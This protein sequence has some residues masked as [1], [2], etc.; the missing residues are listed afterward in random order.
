MTIILDNGHGNNT[1][2]KCSPD[3]I[4]FEWKWTRHFA[5]LLAE[6]LTSR[7]I[8]VCMLVPED[9]DIGL[10]VRAIRANQLCHGQNKRD[11]LLIS[12]HNDA[13]PGTHGEWHDARGLTAFAHIHASEAACAFAKLIQ[14]EARANGF[15]GN[16]ASCAEGFKRANFAI[17]RETIMP[18]VLVENLFQDNKEDVRMLYTE[19]IVVKLVDIYERCICQYI[20]RKMYLL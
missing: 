9:R 18:A 4:H 11:F 6:R 1:A 8:P 12:I 17:L 15:Q 19:E 10:N 7:G 20:D 2:G 5:K 13:A 14:T 16:R 3:G